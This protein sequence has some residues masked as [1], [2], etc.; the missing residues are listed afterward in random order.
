MEEP[1]LALVAAISAVVASAVGGLLAL[2]GVAVQER[3]ATQRLLRQSELDESSRARQRVLDRRLETILD[4]RRAA[5]DLYG[6]VMAW[7]FASD[8]RQLQ[9][10]RSLASPSEH[11]REDFEFVD[12]ERAMLEMLEA[13]RAIL[14]AGRGGADWD[15]HAP[16]V[17]SAYNGIASALLEQEDR[18]QAGVTELPT[19]TEN[20]QAAFMAWTHIVEQMRMVP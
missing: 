10:A 12:N 18:L 2:G 17:I 16:A 6:L 5:N 19:L 11:P 8:A 14:T 9:D 20:G 1:S 4:T 15:L 7:G 13:T 3:L